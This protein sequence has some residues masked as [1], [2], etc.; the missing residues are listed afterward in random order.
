MEFRN[1][2][3]F[4][5]IKAGEF[6]KTDVPCSFKGWDSYIKI[7]FSDERYER[8]DETVYVVTTG[9]NI[10][11]VGEFTYNLRDRWLSRG[12][13]NHHMYSKIEEFLKSNQELSIWL[14]VEPYCNI[15]NHGQLNIS[16]SLEQHILKDTS[17]DWNLRNKHSGSSEWRVKNCIK[18]NTFINVP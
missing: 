4:E 11:Y 13:V 7:D 18:L 15:E 14:A 1:I 2:S 8:A 3:G 17:P 12:Y 6:V 16:K 10:L 5:F 9:N